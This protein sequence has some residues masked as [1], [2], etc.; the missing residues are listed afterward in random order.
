MLAQRGPLVRRQPAPYSQLD[1]TFKNFVLDTGDFLTTV[2][3][4]VENHPNQEIPSVMRLM[5]CIGSESIKEQ[6]KESEEWQK[7]YPGVRRGMM[8]PI[9]PRFR[10]LRGLKTP[11]PS[12]SLKKMKEVG[13]KGPLAG[14]KS[15]GGVLNEV[16]KKEA[17]LTT[18]SPGAFSKKTKGRFKGKDHQKKRMKGFKRHQNRWGV[19]TKAGKKKK[20]AAW[21]KEREKY[22]K[23]RGKTSLTGEF[24]PK[25]LERMKKKGR[26]PRHPE[27]DVPKEL[28]HKKPRH[29]GGSHKKKNLQEVWPWE[30]DKIDPFRHYKGPKPKD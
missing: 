4:C 25:D 24:S 7:K 21:K 22:W 26:A 6:Q 9:G 1:N 20:N 3:D 5:G 29:K 11:K 28:H 14:K 23:E 27:L 19:D 16:V 10:R 18:R 2:N 15:P 12:K 13:P 30:H 8:P 17:P